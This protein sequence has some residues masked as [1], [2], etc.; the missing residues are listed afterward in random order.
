MPFPRYF[1][2]FKLKIQFLANEHN[3]QHKH[4]H[5]PLFN[6]S[7]NFRLHFIIAGE[8]PAAMQRGTASNNIDFRI[9]VY[10][11]AFSLILQNI[12]E[13][14][15]NISSAQRR[16]CQAIDGCGRRGIGGNGGGGCGV[17]N[18]SGC[19]VHSRQ[20][21]GDGCGRDHGTVAARP[22]YSGPTSFSPIKPNTQIRSR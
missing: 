21:A 15:F 1:V 17:G 22:I 9:L 2:V 16:I 10:I 4:T 5:P 11:V 7:T 8:H 12:N 13:I 14:S 19:T 3:K 20:C 6:Q 18:G